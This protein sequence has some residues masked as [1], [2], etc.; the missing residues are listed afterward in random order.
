MCLEKTLKCLREEILITGKLGWVTILEDKNGKKT[1]IDVWEGGC[2][3][4][5]VGE[6]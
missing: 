2:R 5:A 6:V 1:I 4:V 3:F